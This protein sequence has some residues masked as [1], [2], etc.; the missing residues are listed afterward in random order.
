MEQ[1]NATAGGS[2]TTLSVTRGANNTAPLA[3]ILVSAVVYGL[4][5]TG[6]YSDIQPYSSQAAADPTFALVAQGGTAATG[7]NFTN[8]NTPTRIRQGDFQQLPP[9]APYVKQF[10]LE[11]GFEIHPGRF[12]Q[13]RCTFGSGSVGSYSYVIFQA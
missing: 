2:T 4:P 6:V 9:T 3:S 13:I 7:F 11:R 1:M 12:G 8:Y 5:G 10:P